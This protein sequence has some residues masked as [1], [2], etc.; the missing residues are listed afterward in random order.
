MSVSFKADIKQVTKALSAAQKK[1]VPKAIASTLN[2]VATSVRRKLLKEI[3][4][5]TGAIQRDIKE[6]TYIIKSNQRKLI[7]SIIG[8]ATL[9]P[10]GKL[11]PKQTRRGVTAGRGKTRRTYRGAF[12]ATMRSGHA[13]VFLR[14]SKRPLPIKELFVTSVAGEMKRKIAIHRLMQLEA[15]LIFKKDFPRQ[16]KFRLD[17]LKL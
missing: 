2:R 11:N 14:K 7:A 12:V 13:G 15:G 8:K 4:L 3:Q 17:K 16:L 6:D 9:I 10:V 5:T 1:V